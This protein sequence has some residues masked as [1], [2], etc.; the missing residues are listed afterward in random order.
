MDQSD[1]VQRNNDVI[2]ATPLLMHSRM[3]VCFILTSYTKWKWSRAAILR[4]GY[5]AVSLH[6]RSGLSAFASLV[7]QE[8]VSL[9]SQLLLWSLDINLCLLMFVSPVNQCDWN[10][11]NAC[12]ESLFTGEGGPREKVCAQCCREAPFP[13]QLYYHTTR[14]CTNHTTSKY[15]PL[16]LQ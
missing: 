10:A 12:C 16:P 9:L 11:S 6:L 8:R 4:A 5:E 3:L 14:H 15:L 13:L 2:A 1:R 7:T